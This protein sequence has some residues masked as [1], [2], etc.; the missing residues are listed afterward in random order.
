MRTLF[1][2][3]R[4]GSALLV[5]L[6]VMGVLIAVSLVLGSLIFRETR[7]TKEFLDAGRAYYAAESGIE[8]ALYGLNNQLPGWQPEV[9][10]DGDGYKSIEVDGEKL[11]VGEYR[12]AN[13][14]NAYPCFPDDEFDRTTATNREF[15]DILDLNKSITIPLFVV[16]EQAD[17]EI[18][19]TP[20]TDFTV[21]FFAPFNPKEDLAFDIGFNKDLL[22]GWDVLRW[23]VFG[24]TR[25][26]VTGGGP[27]VTETISDFTAMSMLNVSTIDPA[28]NVNQD[29]INSNA[30]APSWFGTVDC[31]SPG[32]DAQK[33]SRYNNEIDCVDYYIGGS[34]N[35]I[36]IDTE[37]FG[38]V[39]EI[40]AGNC[41]HTEAREYYL[42]S[43]DGDERK[44]ESE[45]IYNCYSIKTFLTNHDLNY[46]TLTNLINPAVFETPSKR[47]LARLFFRVELFSDDGP[48][49]TV[50]EYA[51]ITANG[52]SGDSKQ[53]INVKI[54]RGSFMPVFHFSLYS[55]YM[56]DGHGEEYW[57]AEDEEEAL[58]PE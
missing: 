44:V 4:C 28:G 47:Q 58:L 18:V 7:I 8:I 34:N 16:K 42:Y 53:S 39:S 56:A 10:G 46:L 37:S 5:A 35:A 15:Y 22:A 48:A 50:R 17:G 1:L 43:Y 31:D 27:K 49:E 51:D 19:P 6:L 20:V 9:D 26:D 54:K 12:L 3:N 13:R 40:V 29:S 36:K 24:I 23:K 2:K 41:S 11:T 30:T 38:Q 52:Y 14:C 55:T 33:S 32:N 21:E 25:D 45:N 57:Y